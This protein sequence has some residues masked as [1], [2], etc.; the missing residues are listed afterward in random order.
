MLERI[1]IISTIV[2]AI[3]Y[4]MQDGE[5]FGALGNWYDKHLPEKLK[6]PVFDCPV[7]MVPW[8]GTPLFLFFFVLYPSGWNWEYVFTKYL[9]QEWP[10]L[11]MTILSSTG[12][13]AIINKMFPPEEDWEDEPDGQ[14]EE[15]VPESKSKKLIDISKRAA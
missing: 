12:L 1:V 13:N 2:F 9:P 4:T 5:I 11:L 7:C 15:D 14:Y 8:Y 6:A 10:L 3:W